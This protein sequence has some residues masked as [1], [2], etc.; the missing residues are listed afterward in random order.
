MQ[1]NGNAANKRALTIT[2]KYEDEES[3]VQMLER[4]GVSACARGKLA[5]D[6]FTSMETLVLNYANDVDSFYSYLKALN[7]AFGGSNWTIAIRF[8]PIVIKRLSAVLFHF[9]QSVGCIHTIPDIDNIDEPMCI[10]LVQVHDTYRSRK[11]AEGED[12]AIIEL[13]ELKGHIN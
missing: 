9:V 8:S 4:I 5:E 1:A 6:D 11:D 10:H 12:E 3:F 2:E 13:P 7:K